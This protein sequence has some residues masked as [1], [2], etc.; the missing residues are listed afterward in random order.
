MVRTALTLSALLGEPFRI[1]NIR[2][3]RP[4]PG[5]RPQH[6]TAVRAMADICDAQISGAE[7]DATSMTFRPGALEG[8][9]VE[10]DIGT[11]G[12][13]TLL[14]D[15]VLPLATGLEGSLTISATGG[16]DVKWSPTAAYFEEV[17]L[18]LLEPFGLQASVSF[19]RTGFYP[20]GGGHGTLRLEPSSLQPIDLTDRGSYVGARI[21]SKASRVLEQRSV[22]ERQADAAAEVVSGADL[23]IR[24]QSTAYVDTYS[25][26][27]SIG[28]ELE[29]EDSRAGFDALGERGKPAEAVG[30]AAAEA[31]LSFNAGRA[32]VDD[33]MADQLLVF[34]A[35]AGGEV[36]IPRVTEHVE[37]GRCLLAA[38]D[39]DIKLAR[40]S[41]GTTLVRST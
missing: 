7:V 3:A 34:L 36:L 26:G 10:V 39:V 40:Q 33:H 25:T 38:F 19:D 8:G 24:E 32:A 11:A 14:F 13:I 20:A 5:L 23:E 18:P 41:D 15:A 30:R 27:S 37:T 21:S 9:S 2:G 6:L 31:A 17:K 22:A 16:T 4:N 12:S 35:L 29:Y 28:I 1:E